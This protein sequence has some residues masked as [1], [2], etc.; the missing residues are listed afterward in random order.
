MK[1]VQT[2]TLTTE[3]ENTCS[4]SE[5]PTSSSCGEGSPKVLKGSGLVGGKAKKTKKVSLSLPFF[6]TYDCLL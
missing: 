1:A 4:S 5:E 3:Q 6:V 2:S